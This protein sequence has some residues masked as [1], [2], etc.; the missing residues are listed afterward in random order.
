ML[1]QLSASDG[2]FTTTAVTSPLVHVESDIVSYFHSQICSLVFN[3]IYKI[4]KCILSL[5]IPLA[6]NT[7]I[8]GWTAKIAV[9][10]L[11]TLVVRGNNYDYIHTCMTLVIIASVHPCNSPTTLKTMLLQC[12]N[13][14]PTILLLLHA[15]IW[16]IK[17]VT[18]IVQRC[19]NLLIA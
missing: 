18:P 6:L 13:C 19:L 1:V 15:Y 2:V 12:T 8:H 14:S 3:I 7:G 17:L 11:T 5:R 10:P 16:L 4:H 9:T